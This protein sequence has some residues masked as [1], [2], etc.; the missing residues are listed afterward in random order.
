MGDRDD[1]MQDHEFWL[2]LEF[3]LSGWF[4]ECGDKSM[5][6]LWCDGVTPVSTE[7]TKD[8]IVVRGTAWIAD[9][10]RAQTKYSFEASIPQ[11]MLARRRDDFVVA[12][13][14]VDRDRSS[15]VFSIASPLSL[16]NISLQADRER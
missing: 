7:N 10:S 6:G 9:G 16:P 2:K 13:L 12:D 3:W 14:L 1:V 5:G 4:R 11:R 8:G 15:I